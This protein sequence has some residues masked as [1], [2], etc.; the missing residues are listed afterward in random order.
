MDHSKR[1]SSKKKVKSPTIK[2]RK[3]DDMERLVSG[4]QWTTAATQKFI[5]C[6]TDDEKIKQLFAMFSTTEVMYKGDIRTQGN[7]DFQF[8]NGLWCI[9]QQLDVLQTQFVCRTLDRLLQNA[10]QRSQAANE[11]GEKISIEDL[12]SD[13]FDQLHASFNDT[14]QNEWHFTPDLTK[15][16]LVFFNQ[17]FFRPLRLLL[18]TFTHERGVQHIPEKRTVFSPIQP[19]PLSEC[20]EEFPVLSDE[21]SFRPLII[22]KGTMNLEEAREMIQQY[23]D[24]MIDTINKRYDSLQE[25]ISKVQP[26]L[27]SDR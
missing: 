15:K 5:D 9:E 18:Y 6:Q 12:K 14:N 8:A 13:L 20:V 22:P 11:R 16:I 25:M 21:M 10:I 26:P 1:G 19:V 24:D 23:T 17:V 27:Q 4:A 3:G 7:I 2:G